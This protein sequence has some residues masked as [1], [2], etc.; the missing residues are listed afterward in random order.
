[1]LCMEEACLVGKTL[2]RILALA[3]IMA[4]LMLLVP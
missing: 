3:A 1:M 2:I 4:L